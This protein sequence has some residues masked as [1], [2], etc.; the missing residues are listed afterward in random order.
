MT[1]Q[2]LHPLATLATFIGLAG[3]ALTGRNQILLL[4]SRSVMLLAMIHTT[5]GLGGGGVLLWTG[6]LIA[7]A[8][9]VAV[10]G[11]FSARRSASECRGSGPRLSMSAHTH[12]ALD[13]VAMAALMLAMHAPAGDAEAMRTAAHGVHATAATPLPVVA[14]AMGVCVGLSSIARVRRPRALRWRDVVELAD[15]AGMGL[16]MLLMAAAVWSMVQS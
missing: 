3:C 16:G 1:A 15:A 9:A 5:A 7:G 14:V 13:A 2:V 4:V 11:R 8:M 10:A 12:I 6:G